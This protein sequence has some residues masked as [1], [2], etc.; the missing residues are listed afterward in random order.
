MLLMDF[1]TNDVELDHF[2]FDQF[3]FSDPPIAKLIN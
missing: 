1:K 3:H 2:I